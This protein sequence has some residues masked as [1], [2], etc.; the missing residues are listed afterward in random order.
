MHEMSLN[1][2]LLNASTPSIRYLT[3]TR[4]LDRPEA[5]PIVQQTRQEMIS[6]GPI[7]AIL[8]Q[9]SATGAWS[10]DR[11]YYTPKYTSTHWSMLLLAELGADPA[12]A[13]LQ[14]GARY[15]L[16]VNKERG[17]HWIDGK[18]RGLSCFWGNV[19]RYAVHSRLPDDP[20]LENVISNLTR[21]VKTS[22]SCQ[23]N[24][25]MPCAWGAA[26]ALWAFAGLPP[27]SKTPAVQ[28]AIESAC[29]F[30]LEEYDL[31]KSDYPTTS[32]GKVSV[33]WRRLSFPLFY[34]ADRLMVLRALAELNMLDHP[35]AR[36]T[37]DWLA[38]IRLEDGRWHGSSPFYQRTWPVLA[39]SQEAE[40]WVTLQS[41]LVLKAAG[42]A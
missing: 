5:D 4:L 38:S 6:A 8:A 32:K 21:E 34:Q 19:L 13:R 42:R 25:G 20:R 41:A 22:W 26:R 2:W 15:M 31:M 33:L 28:A 40:R 16:E 17:I 27:A 9:Q 7:P 3:L 39:D 24:Y 36:S 37:L 23:Y 35:G 29:H 18:S 1:N 10:C 30:L 14:G 11:S 12:D